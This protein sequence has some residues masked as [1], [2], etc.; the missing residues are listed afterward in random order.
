MVFFFFFRN[1]KN[2][3]DAL[4]FVGKNPEERRKQDFLM[5]QIPKILI[6]MEKTE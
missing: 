1:R 4:H 5:T 2:F 3:V 6:I